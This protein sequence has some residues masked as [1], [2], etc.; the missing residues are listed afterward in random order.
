MRTAV[1]V[2]PAQ[3][4]WPARFCLRIVTNDQ[5]L[6]D[7]PPRRRRRHVV[8]ARRHAHADQH[9]WCG[10][11]PD[12]HGDDVAAGLKL[13]YMRQGSGGEANYGALQENRRK[14]L[15]ASQRIHVRVTVRRQDHDLR[16]VGRCICA[17]LVVARSRKRPPNIYPFSLICRYQRAVRDA[18]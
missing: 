15:A 16:I 1:F 14:Y 17:L 3:I 2:S 7:R 8:G 18:L 12:Q 4:Y 11:L 13:R 6:V 5:Y 10:V 9:L